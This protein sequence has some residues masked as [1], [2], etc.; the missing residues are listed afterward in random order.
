MNLSDYKFLLHIDAAGGAKQHDWVFGVFS[1][2]VGPDDVRYLF[3]FRDAD[4]QQFGMKPLAGSASWG[5]NVR[6]LARNVIAKPSLRKSLLSTDPKLE[7]LWRQ[8]RV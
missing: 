2:V 5:K 1:H 8:N 3:S 7:E 4:R 6:K